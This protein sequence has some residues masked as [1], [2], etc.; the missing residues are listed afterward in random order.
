MPASDS[1][2][3]S[4]PSLSGAEDTP[5]ANRCRL[6]AILLALAVFALGTAA[7]YLQP[8]YNWD[9][10]AYI[11]LMHESA[12]AANA[13][14][15]HE[16]TYGA[17]R[18]AVSKKDFDFLITSH[19]GYRQNTYADPESFAQQLDWYAIRVAY[20]GLAQFLTELGLHETEA[21]RLL[22]AVSYLVICLTVLSH[23]AHLYPRR[24]LPLL[25][26][27]MVA[28]FPALISTGRLVTPDLMSA[29]GII[30]GFSLLLRERLILG[31]LVLLATVFVRTDAG[32]FAIALTVPVLLA[33]SQPLARR[34]IATGLLLMSAPLVLGLNA[35]F[36]YP[37]WSKLITVASGQKLFYPL[38]DEVAPITPIAYLKM[39]ASTSIRGFIIPSLWMTAIFLLIIGRKVI[40]DFRYLDP[41]VLWCAAIL[42]FI[43]T[44][45]ALGIVVQERYF[46]FLP[47]VMFLIWVHF[48]FSRKR[49]T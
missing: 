21:L 34:A 29:C 4:A 3:T 40:R 16:R 47:I 8:K 39:L 37:G 20:W 6:F 25:M 15:I 7:I 32:V 33:S 2:S 38:T 48:Q 45:V 14:E 22:S 43:P 18:E 42:V 9:M 10:M 36:D 17:V 23:L 41:V 13:V 46:V 31:A 49:Q 28:L 1:L 5:K 12:G 44:R 24:A 19:E 27:L 26:S 30:L 11:G 35:A